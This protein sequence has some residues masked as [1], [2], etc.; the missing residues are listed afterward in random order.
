MTPLEKALEAKLCRWVND[1][2]GKSLKWVCPGWSG[3]PDRIVLMPG[4]H[5]H[6]VEMKRPKDGKLSA[7]QKKWQLWLTDL[8]FRSWVIWNHDDLEDFLLHIQEEL[9]DI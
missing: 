2:G 1:L 5:I 4:G 8:G 7:L 6:F 9:K 3:V